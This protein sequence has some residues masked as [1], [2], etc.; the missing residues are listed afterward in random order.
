MIYHILPV[1]MVILSHDMRFEN[2]I[3][4]V[5]GDELGVV[6][7]IVHPGKDKDQCEILVEEIEDEM[8]E[9]IQVYVESCIHRRTRRR[10]PKEIKMEQMEDLKEKIKAQ[11]ETGFKVILCKKLLIIHV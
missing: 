7:N 3:Y 4:Y 2:K 11:D 1:T 6:F 9:K 10:T 5:S 8:V